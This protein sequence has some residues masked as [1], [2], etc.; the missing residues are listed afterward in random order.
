MKVQ[1]AVLALTVTGTV[2]IPISKV[3]ISSVHGSA[4]GEVEHDIITSPVWRSVREGVK[5]LEDVHLAIGKDPDIVLAAIGAAP[6]V[7][8]SVSIA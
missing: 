7:T 4:A 2:A 1:K 8:V 5:S 3:Q 6:H